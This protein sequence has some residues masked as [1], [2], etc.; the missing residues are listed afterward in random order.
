MT[1]ALSRTGERRLA[2]FELVIEK[3]LATFQ[4]VGEALIAI[5][6]ERLYRAEHET[7]EAYCKAR[8]KFS[9]RRARQLMSAAEIGTMVPVENERQARALEPI[10]DDPDAMREVVA[11]AEADGDKSASNLSKY[12]RNLK[13]AHTEGGADDDGGGNEGDAGNHSGDGANGHDV[14]VADPESAPPLPPTE[15]GAREFIDAVAREHPE[16]TVADA[17]NRERQHAVALTE[18]SIFDVVTA[19]AVDDFTTNDLREFC[20]RLS[21]WGDAIVTV[22]R[23]APQE[24]FDLGVTEAQQRLDLFDM[25][26]T[27]LIVH[28]RKLAATRDTLSREIAVLDALIA[29]MR[30]DDSL[31]T[32]GDA[33]RKLGLAA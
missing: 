20:E 3:G 6:D 24:D 11:Q 19:I 8:W 13:H 31:T 9:D 2:T 18:M 28:R 30:D 1:A 29:A 5:R 21:G 22:D 32:A 27:T 14:G 12:V 25:D 16:W 10:K 17:F 26:V 15:I 23:H 4:E 33:F 7:F